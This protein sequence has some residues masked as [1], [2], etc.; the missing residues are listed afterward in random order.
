[1]QSLRELAERAWR[2]AH[3]DALTAVKLLRDWRPDLGLREAARVIQEHKPANA[4]H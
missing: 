1:M 3:G 4:V 2:D